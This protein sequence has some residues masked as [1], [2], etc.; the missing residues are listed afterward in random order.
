MR[1]P[2]KI[3][4]EMKNLAHLNSNE[5]VS[6][7]I[8]D[9]ISSHLTAIRRPGDEITFHS[10]LNHWNTAFDLSH[11][12]THTHKSIVFTDSD[13]FREKSQILCIVFDRAT[14]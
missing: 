8:F 9:A 13:V 10:F 3:R 7:Q 5:M 11:T 2:E 6:A 1:Q 14:V 12:L 4:K